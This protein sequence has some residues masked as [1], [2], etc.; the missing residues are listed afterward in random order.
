MEQITYTCNGPRKEISKDE[1][2]AEIKK[3]LDGEEKKSVILTDTEKGELKETLEEGLPHVFTIGKTFGLGQDGY[4][5]MKE[6]CGANIT[7]QVQEVP[8]DGEV[9][10]IECPNCGNKAEVRKVMTAE[11]ETHEAKNGEQKKP[12]KKAKQ[13]PAEP[14]Q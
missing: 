12:S 3:L 5:F 11:L 7:K 13:Q 6:N 10:E 14:K 8:E 4:A 1:L 2:I 9:H